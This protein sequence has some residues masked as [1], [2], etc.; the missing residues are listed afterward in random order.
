MGTVRTLAIQPEE[1]HRLAVHE[2]GHT[3]VAYFLPHADPIYKVSIIP[4]GRA[5]GATHQLPE[6]ERHTLPEDYLRD[7]LVVMMG[8]RSAEQELLG[9]VS[10]GADDD[11]AQATA[12]ARAMVSR[13]GMSKE[14]G[15]VD[16]RDTEEHPFL[17]KEMAQPRHFSENSAQ[18]VDKAVKQLLGDAEKQAIDLI[19]KHRKLLDN[20]INELEEHET[21]DQ[22]QIKLCL[23]NK[24]SQLKT[25]TTQSNKY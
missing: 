6:Q 15:P 21:L 16:L 17:G 10:S 8:G 12:L 2:S 22:E 11:I 23:G 13:W 4:R 3:L 20:L 19:A 18:S 5:L 7:R 9:S 14:I 1:R 24:V 25:T